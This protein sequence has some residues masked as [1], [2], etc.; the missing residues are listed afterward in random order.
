MKVMRTISRYF[1]M[2]SRIRAGRM[3]RVTEDAP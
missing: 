2:S 3:P 1:A